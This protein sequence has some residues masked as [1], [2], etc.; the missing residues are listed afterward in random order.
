[1]V[2][3]RK[4][5]KS[6]KSKRG[7][8]ATSTVAQPGEPAATGNNPANIK[9]PLIFSVISV[10]GKNSSPQ[11][12]TEKLDTDEWWGVVYNTYNT[13]KS[14]SSPNVSDGNPKFRFK[15]IIPFDDNF[16]TAIT[17]YGDNGTPPITILQPDWSYNAAT[18]QHGGE[19]RND[20]MYIVDAV[21]VPAFSKLNNLSIISNAAAA[22]KLEPKH[23]VPQLNT[24][25]KL[26]T[27]KQPAAAQQPAA[28]QQ[29]TS[30]GNKI[31]DFC[32]FAK[33]TQD[34]RDMALASNYTSAAKNKICVKRDRASWISEDAPTFEPK[35]KP[36]TIDP[37]ISENAL[38][39]VLIQFMNLQSL[40]IRNALGK[41]LSDLYPIFKGSFE[42]KFKE[43]FGP[44]NV[45]YAFNIKFFISREK[46]KCLHLFLLAMKSLQAKNPTVQYIGFPKLP[47]IRDKQDENN[48]KLDKYKSALNCCINN[49]EKECYD[50]EDKFWGFSRRDNP[51]V[52]QYMPKAGGRRKTRRIRKTRRSCRK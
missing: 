30:K 49:P 7:G 23:T 35:Y 52:C 32:D 4:S 42:S 12:R 39:S 24:T 50:G 33:M 11:P 21:H 15:E 8:E 29:P 19:D 38:T 37:T 43:P 22:W 45:F 16:V 2:H 25:Q 20:A 28:T 13:K 5:R 44:N 10:N 9:E 34:E 1:M 18:T 36:Y 31:Y 3:S 51:V 46:M 6:R 41:E 40:E 48:S 14:E 17:F 27:S 26:N 47:P